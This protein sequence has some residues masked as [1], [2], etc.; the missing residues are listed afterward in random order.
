[1]G[2][3]KNPVQLADQ[4]AR[5]EFCNSIDRNFSVIAPA[6]VGKTTSIV[7][8]IVAI[9]LKDAVRLPRL[10]VVTYTKKAADEM[11]LRARQEIVKK[12]SGNII[13]HFNQAFFGTIHS[14]CL[15]LIN[16]YGSYLG[17]PGKLDL[18]E[19]DDELWLSCIRQKDR[20]V[21]FLPDD[22]KSSF[23]R[24][25]S[26]SHLLKYAKSYSC[27]SR[28]GDNYP[29]FPQ[30]NFNELLNFEPTARNKA[31]VEEGKRL[32]EEWLKGYE[33]HITGL[34]MPDYDYGGKD[35]Q[36]AWKAVFSPLKQWV[37]EVGS[38]VLQKIAE[39][40]Q[41]FRLRKGV[42]KYDDMI[43]LATRILADDN[44]LA[45]VQAAESIV[46]LDEAQDTDAAQFDIFLKIAGFDSGG[47]A[48]K[49]NGRFCMVGDPQQ[50]IYSSRADLPTY[51]RIHNQMTTSG[52]STALK[53]SV[54]M[55][56]DRQIVS[57]A[58]R[59]FPNILNSSIRAGQIEFSVL[60]PRPW[61]G[62]GQVIKIP[63]SSENEFE[64]DDH[65]I[66]WEAKEVAQL[67]S[68]E[69]KIGLGIDDWKFVSILSPRNRWLIPFAKALQEQGLKCQIH[70]KNDILGDNPAY[71]WFTALMLIAD[72][73]DDSFELAGVLREIYGISDHDIATYVCSGCSLQITDKS[74]GE[75]PVEAIL[76]DLNNISGAARGL[77]LRALAE[78]W[79]NKTDLRARVNCLP[80]YVLQ[81]NMVNDLLLNA[82]AAEE[83]GLSLHDWVEILK[84]KYNQVSG[85]VVPLPDHI[86][87]YS[88]HKAKGLE[89]KVV[90][91]PCLFRAIREPRPE[92]PRIIERRGDAV[93]IL[94][95][96]QITEEDKDFEKNKK[97]AE[98]ERLLYVAMTRPR[99]KLILIDDENLFKKSDNSFADLL[100]ILPEKG[101]REYWES[102]PETVLPEDDVD[103]KAPSVTEDWIREIATIDSATFARGKRNAKA[104]F[105]RYTP[106]GLA[107]HGRDFYPGEDEGLITHVGIDYGN[108]WHEMMEHAPW[109]LSKSELA[110]CFK[111]KL[112][113]CPLPE[114][115]AIEVDTLLAS[116]FL[117]LLSGRT[118]L[119]VTE[120]P[121]LW[122]KDDKAA[123]EG[124]I[125]FLA[126]N[127]KEAQWLLLDWKTD[128]I[129]GD[130]A[131]AADILKQRYAPQINLYAEALGGI[132][133]IPGNCFIYS[134]H[135]GELIPL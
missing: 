112:P 128:F 61:A 134:T 69:G 126:F 88:C 25:A 48:A 105:S 11:Q 132:Y 42:L 106:S 33:E 47:I 83:Q 94:D 49:D 103:D 9:A 64:K 19:D 74:E 118:W 122:K 26:L 8:R 43:Q 95:S 20:I 27:A 60:E 5:D 93:F 79:V 38:I 37:S 68:K 82:S 86:Q 77:S 4:P 39:D 2:T 113:L 31:K 32:L 65:A 81:E 110:D 111:N 133:R 59:I 107:S 98:Y 23:L 41:R 76:N 123:I 117:D 78:Y 53:F 7:N 17:I 108:W 84:R 121:F 85:E 87:L 75:G 10:V 14:Y 57:H 28:K 96:S 55:R 104:Y 6:G 36:E 22:V 135:K 109:G 71:A 46:I 35:F 13:S 45:K 127:K 29:A 89:W 97:H 116:G 44:L 24:F 18:L 91:L 115:G 12:A 50:S 3:T 52:V 62:E 73:P 100:A 66:E 54:T 114:R 130:S 80:G 125:D 102:L 16:K 72:K 99:E 51:I 90:V 21:D 30:I 92:Y 40:Y 120:V 67:L 15:Y 63:L 34:G 56:C 129:E 58:N 131:T 101:N 70:S 124:I 119:A 1:M